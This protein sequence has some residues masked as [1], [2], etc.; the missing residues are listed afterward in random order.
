[1]ANTVMKNQSSMLMVPTTTLPNLKLLRGGG[2][3][4]GGG[5]AVGVLC[6]ERPGVCA[7]SRPS[8]GES[9]SFGDPSFDLAATRSIRCRCSLMRPFF[10]GGVG[11]SSNKGKT[12]GSP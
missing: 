3:A 12:S 9:S 11:I 10:G 4:G 8:L 2:G 1:M 5:D 7:W 6:P